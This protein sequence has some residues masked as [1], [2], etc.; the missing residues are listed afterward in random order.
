MSIWQFTPLWIGLLVEFLG[1]LYYSKSKLTPELESDHGAQRRVVHDAYSAAVTLAMVTNVA[2]LSIS[3]IA[4]Q[5]R[6]WASLPL[7]RELGFTRV[8]LP[9]GVYPIKPMKDLVEAA[10]DMLIYDQYCGSAALLIWAWAVGRRRRGA[11]DSS[12][13]LNDVC[14]ALLGAVSAGPAGAATMLMAAGGEAKSSVVNTPRSK[15]D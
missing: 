8:F 6:L 7:L 9:S 12:A 4:M 11:K 15:S 10:H 5:P 2:A 14:V 13:K 3:L 1:G